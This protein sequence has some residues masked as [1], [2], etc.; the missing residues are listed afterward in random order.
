MPVGGPQ[1]VHRVRIDA[2]DEHAAAGCHQAAGP[3]PQRRL[4][5]DFELGRNRRFACPA[6]PRVVPVGRPIA[7]RRIVVVH[8][9][10]CRALKQAVAGFGVRRLVAAFALPQRG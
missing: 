8:L 3:R 9:A 7:G 10:K 5:G 1:R 4:P 2:G 6:A